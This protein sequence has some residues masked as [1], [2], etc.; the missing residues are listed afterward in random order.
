MADPIQFIFAIAVLIFSVV[1]HEVSHGVM[2]LRLGDQTAKR[3]GRLTLNP[4][5]HLDLVG[6]FILPVLLYAL[7]A[8]ILL[9]WAKPVPYNPV[10]F[11]DQKYGSLKVALVGPLSNL[12]LAVVFGLIIQGL[13]GL[14]TTQ[15]VEFL[16]Y[17]VLINSLLF[18]FNIMP[19]PPLDGSKVLAAFL[20]PRLAYRMEHVGLEGLFLIL[21]FLYFFSDFIFGSAFGLFRFLTGT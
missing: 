2:A 13:G 18:I 3:L 1:V 19:V 7:N 14:L 21:I 17:I 9:G 12:G 4:I 16:S 11:K 6:S 10:F 8:P 15:M 5:P 20:P